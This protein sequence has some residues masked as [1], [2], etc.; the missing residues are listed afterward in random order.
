[1]IA[2]IGEL[3]QNDCNDDKNRYCEIEALGE[4]VSDGEVMGSNKIRIVREITGEELEFLKGHKNGNTGLFNSG[5]CNSGYR[6]SGDS[7]SGYANSGDNN[8]GDNNSG[9]NNSG[10]WN[11]CNGSNGVFCT[12]EPTIKI[13]D[14]DTNMP[15]SEF[16]KSKYNKALTRGGLEITKCIEYT[17]EEKKND[18]NKRLVGGYLKEYAYKEA[19]SNWW[20]VMTE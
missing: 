7:N 16:E 2:T 15:L 11:K 18:E 12:V 10:K 9:D 17:E 3:L 13:F 14:K 4:I 5:N 20:S 1:M 19:C 6:N 8:S